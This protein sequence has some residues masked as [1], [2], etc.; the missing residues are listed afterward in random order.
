MVPRAS[1]SAARIAE[2][3]NTEPDI[4]DPKNQKHLNMDKTKGVIKFNNVSFRYNGAES[5]VLQNISFTARP[6]ETTAFI[7]STGSGKSTLINLIPR[8]YDV[9][10]GS[11][12]IDGINIKDVSQHETP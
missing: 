4:V 12:E 7:G 1:V 5:D 3:L 10:E 2:V 8:F 9:T 6:G 11:I